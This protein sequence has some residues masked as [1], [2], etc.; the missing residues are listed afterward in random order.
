MGADSQTTYLGFRQFSDELQIKYCQAAS[1]ALG[2]DYWLVCKPFVYYVGSKDSDVVVRIEAC[3]LTD[4]AS[5]PRP[6]WWIVPPW[7]RYGAA[8][9]VHDKLCETLTVERVV[10][11]RT[12][13]L[14]IVTTYVPM[15]ITRRECDHILREALHVLGVNRW[16]SAIIY[17]GVSLYRFVCRVHKPEYSIKKGDIEATLR[18]E[19][20]K[21]NNVL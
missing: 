11:E 3:Y 10:T 4:G 14:E 20:E 8:V 2:K 18:V 7:G 1:V 13:D 5:V 17:G 16:I 19:M 15:A 9:V 12:N 6:F 21:G